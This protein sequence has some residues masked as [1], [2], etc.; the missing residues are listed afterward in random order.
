MK[1]VGHRENY[2]RQLNIFL[3][4]SIL[5]FNSITLTLSACGS[6]GGGVPRQISWT[7]P[8]LNTDGSLLTDLSKYR[9]YYGPAANSLE[10][11][12]DIDSNGVTITSYTF[13][14]A[15]QNTLASLFSKNSTHFFALTSVSRKGWMYR[16]SDLSNI[17]IY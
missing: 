11:V 12:L 10:A 14:T 9:L 2:I 17:I 1:S 5:L 16:E 13:S 8:T 7:P 15:D 6:G 3:G 4:A